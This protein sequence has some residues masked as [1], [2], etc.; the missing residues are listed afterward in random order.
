[1]AKYQELPRMN[2]SASGEKR[3]AVCVLLDTSE[4][5]RPYERQLERALNEL[6]AKLMA[7]DETRGSVEICVFCFD[8]QPVLKVPF[9]P[10]DQMK[11]PV[12][13]C[14]GLT[15]T[16][17]ALVAAMEY[18]NQRKQ[19]YRD[20]AL[21]YYQPW[22]WLL[23]DGDS[24]DANTRDQQEMSAIQT[25]RS[26][27][28][29]R[30]LSFYALAIGDDAN[31][32]ELAG[33]HKDGKVYSL[34]HSDLGKAFEYLTRTVVTRVKDTDNDDEDLVVAVPVG[35]TSITLG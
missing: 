9:G 20:A 16:R 23:T 12:M 28:D 29:A 30:K 19:D 24:T 13:D 7:N 15:N 6:K 3:L 2:V 26:L 27:Q 34:D 35:L 8:D 1:M 17:K 10:L 32:K 22:I 14:A 4:S 25:L 11:I 21:E 18:V 5:M 31:L 33:M